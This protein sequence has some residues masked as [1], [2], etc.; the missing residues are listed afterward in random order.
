MSTTNQLMATLILEVFGHA[1]TRIGHG[2]INIQ[3]NQGSK[4][5]EQAARIPEKYWKEMTIT[6]M[7]IVVRMLVKQ[8]EQ[9]LTRT[10]TGQ[11]CSMEKESTGTQ[12]RCFSTRD[13]S[14]Q[15]NFTWLVLW[16]FQ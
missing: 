10:Q 16:L 13:L 11:T 7:E 12:S 6:S 9:G 3:A 14:V 2:S 4:Y 1:V 5:S 15:L 8:S